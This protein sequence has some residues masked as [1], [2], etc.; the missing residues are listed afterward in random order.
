[1]AVCPI[2]QHCAAPRAENKAFPFCSARCKQIDLAKWL[3]GEY[4]I[5]TNET[6]DQTSNLTSSGGPSLVEQELAA[7]TNRKEI[8]S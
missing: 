1:M 7:G 4:R 3:T 5:L 8:P 6:P 2:C